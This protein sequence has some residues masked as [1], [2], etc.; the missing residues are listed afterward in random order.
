MQKFN[1]KDTGQYLR[2]AGTDLEIRAELNNDS[3]TIDVLKS[4]NC[5]HRLTIDDVAGRMEHG[6]IADMFAREDRIALSQL[7]LE[8]DEFVSD[9]NINQG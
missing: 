7:T 1:S 8:A 2:F 3:V 4:G 6:W 9:L 5:V